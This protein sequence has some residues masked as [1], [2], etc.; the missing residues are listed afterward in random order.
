MAEVGSQEAADSWRDAASSPPTPRHRVLTAL[1]GDTVVGFAALAPA[2]DPDLDPS[3]DHEVLALCVDPAARGA[4]HGSRLV[5]AAADL[6]A[7]DGVHVL[8]TWLAP[9]ETGLRRF[10]DGA[11]WAPDGAARSLDLRGDGVVV[12][13]QVRLRAALVDPQ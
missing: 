13:Q 6:A 5:N 3:T 9:A 10:L 12:V 8:H 1:V 2:T 11:G 4:G 7:G